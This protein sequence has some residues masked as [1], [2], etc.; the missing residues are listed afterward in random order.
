MY[1]TVFPPVLQIRGSSAYARGQLVT[2]VSNEHL[3]KRLHVSCTFLGMRS[4]PSVP[5]IL[6]C[7][8]SLPEMLAEPNRH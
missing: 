6:S 1:M 3:L 4:M 5:N 8:K 7:V 2:R